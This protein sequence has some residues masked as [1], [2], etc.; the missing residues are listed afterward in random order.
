MCISKLTHRSIWRKRRF[1]IASRACEVQVDP[2]R[3]PISTPTPLASFYPRVLPKIPSTACNTR[4]AHKHTRIYWILYY[5][6]GGSIKLYGSENTIVRAR[7]LGDLSC[8][9][10][11]DAAMYLPFRSTRDSSSCFLGNAKRGASL[12][13]LEA[14]ETS[15]AGRVPIPLSGNRAATTSVLAAHETSRDR[16]QVH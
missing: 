14:H 11:K 13:F 10:C 1:V 2:G 16:N 5:V 12:P 15:C 6:F 7:V 8:A 4:S 3:Y 9:D